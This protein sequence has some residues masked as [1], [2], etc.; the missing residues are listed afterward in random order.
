MGIT[1]KSVKK[2]FVFIFFILITSVAYNLG[3]HKKIEF[4]KQVRIFYQD[5]QR[6]IIT[7]RTSFYNT[8][9][10]FYVRQFK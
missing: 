1:K 2:T 7:I 9:T 4:K 8:D 5:E 10:L 6:A 3:L